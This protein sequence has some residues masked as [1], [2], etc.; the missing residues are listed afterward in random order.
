MTKLTLRQLS[1]MIPLIETL[2]IELLEA[3][4][5]RVRAQMAWSPARCTAGGVLHGGALMSLADTCGGICAFLNLPAGMSR[6]TTTE[7]KTYLVRAVTEGIVTA[8]S[9]PLHQ[10]QTLAVIETVLTDDADRL[11]AKTAQT[12]MFLA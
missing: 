5:D 6:T 10:G 7:S 1:E 8:T 3:S 11:V 9:T 12:Q 2:D 4:V